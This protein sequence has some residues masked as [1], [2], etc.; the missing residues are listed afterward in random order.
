MQIK[1]TSSPLSHPS[2]FQLIRRY[3]F[4]QI[5]MQ[6]NVDSSHCYWVNLFQF[7]CSPVP[8]SLTALLSP[9]CRARRPS[10]LWSIDGFLC[11][12]HV[13]IILRKR[14]TQTERENAF[15]I[16][17]F[18]TLMRRQRRTCQQF[19]SDKEKKKTFPS[20][21][22]LNRLV[23][24]LIRQLFYQTLEVICTGSLVFVDLCVR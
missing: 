17:K 22:L 20:V 4:Q 2:I 12:I 23:V 24:E 13:L 10:A 11:K 1:I 5:A 3:D 18:I 21:Q 7:N 8:I 9:A 14:E 6:F 19:I 16:W 15:S